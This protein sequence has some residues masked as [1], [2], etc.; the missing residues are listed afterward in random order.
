M[1]RPASLAGT[2]PLWM[3]GRQAAI[4]QGVDPSR[5]PAC[6]PDLKTAAG[7]GRPGHAS[8]A[9]RRAARSAIRVIT[10]ATSS[11]SNARPCPPGQ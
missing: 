5:R 2:R 4:D 3:L 1:T 8:D 9:P 11:P 6:A 7:R 10:P